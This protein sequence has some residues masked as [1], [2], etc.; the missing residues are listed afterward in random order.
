MQGILAALPSSPCKC[1]FETQ[2]AENTEMESHML[3]L[4][5]KKHAQKDYV[6]VFWGL[7]GWQIF[8]FR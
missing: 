8:E 6:S 1:G 5:A 2:F 7:L 3:P 4:K